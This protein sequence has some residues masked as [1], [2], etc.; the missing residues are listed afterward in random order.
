MPQA[1]TRWARTTLAWCH[2]FE[3]GRS[4]YEGAGHTDAAWTDPLFRQHVLAG[5]EWTAGVVEGGGN[6]VTFGEV[7]EIV[8]SLDTSDPGDAVAV[9]GIAGR[10]DAAQ[11]AADGGDHSAALVEI[12]QA[13]DLAEGLTAAAG[14][15]ALLVT[16]LSDLTDWQTALRGDDVDLAFTATAE[17][18]SLAANHLAVRV[19]NDETSPVDV[20]VTTAYGTRTF[21]DVAPGKSAYQSFATRLAQVPAG[22]VEVT[23]T[24]ERDGSEVSEHTA[25]AYFGS[26]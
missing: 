12:A 19:I 14:D 3:G 17:V 16:K 22:E 2:N 25:I 20:T 11:A 8:E 5:V 21:Q 9:A 10:L 15:A 7:D 13:A 1:A 6:C 23:V 26:H 18:R 24:A 4:W